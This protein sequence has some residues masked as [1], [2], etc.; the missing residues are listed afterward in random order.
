[1]GEFSQKA[2]GRR[3]AYLRKKLGLKQ[4][5][6]ASFLGKTVAAVASWEVGRNLVPTDVVAKLVK[7]Y[8]VNPLWLFFGEGS[9]FLKEVTSEIEEEKLRLL[10]KLKGKFLLIKETADDMIK[11]GKY[12]V[13]AGKKL[14]KLLEEILGEE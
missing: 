3:I 7:E 11:S 5:D 8:K 6:L 4:K 13:S 14:E 12:Q 1:L 2:L 10:K 9:M